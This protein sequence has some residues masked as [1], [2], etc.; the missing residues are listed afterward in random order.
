MATLVL[1]HGSYFGSFS[2][3]WVVPHLRAAGHDVHTP[4]LTGV[5]ERVHLAGPHVDLDTHIS[6]VV[7]VLYF[8]DLT[9][10]VLVGWS[11]G[12]MIV[13]GVADRVPERVAQIIYLDADVPRDGDTSS[14]PPEV[15]ASASSRRST[16]P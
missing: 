7:N 14:R 11:Y 4:S 15:C 1:V 8:E 9:G 12:G 16:S 2:W 13:A 3:R 6:D 10:V 5:G